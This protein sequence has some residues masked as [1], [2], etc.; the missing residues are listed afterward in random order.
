MFSALGLYPE[1]PAV[2]GFVIGSPRF[3]AITVHLGNGHTLSITA[4]NASDATPYVQHLLVKGHSS[5]SLWLPLQTFKQDTTLAFTLGRDA[6]N[7]GMGE[8]D[9]PPS[10]GGL[11]E[12]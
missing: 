11:L 1:I 4:P 10:Y 9:A 7:W 2:G 5:T 12:G 6:T 3:S 8:D